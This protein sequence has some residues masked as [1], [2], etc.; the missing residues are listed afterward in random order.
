MTYA[1]PVAEEHQ[2]GAVPDLI[3]ARLQQLAEA[4]PEQRA[5]GVGV[6]LRELQGEV[7]RITRV[8]DEALMQILAEDDGRNSRMIAEEFGVTRQRVDQLKARVRQA[9]QQP[10]GP[11]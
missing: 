9:R 11:A 5:R 3:D 2:D 7:E 8:R 10:T 4:A 1:W 6:L